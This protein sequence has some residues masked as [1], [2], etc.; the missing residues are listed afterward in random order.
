MTKTERGYIDKHWMVFIARGALALL[1]GLLML[2]NYGMDLAVLT[3]PLCVFLLAIGAVD[4][5]NAIFNA[6]KKHDWI[7]CVVDSVID[8]ATSVLLLLLGQNDIVAGIVI[9]ATYTVISGLVDL[10]HAF[11]AREDRTDRFIR[12]LIGALGVVIGIV[13]FNAGKFEISTFLRFFGTYILMV[14]V[15]SIIYGV[16]NRDQSLCYQEELREERL[17]RKKEEKKS[18]WA[19]IRDSFKPAKKASAK[20]AVSA[21]HI[22]K[23]T[24]TSKANKK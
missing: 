22:H 7:N 13:I 19:R 1:I 8:V 2:F 21:H 14:G 16:H 12:L 4:A 20:T 17:E 9:L 11:L 3:V 18:L 23:T 6:D 24:R 15:T 5:A 10:T